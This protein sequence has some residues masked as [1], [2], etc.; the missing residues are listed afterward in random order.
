MST[1]LPTPPNASPDIRCG[2][3]GHPLNGARA[4]N[5]R[6]CPG[7]GGDLAD[8]AAP[9]TPETPPA[10]RTPWAIALLLLTGIAIGLGITALPRALAGLFLGDAPVGMI[11]ALTIGGCWWVVVAPL[12]AMAWADNL[13]RV[14]RRRD[15]LPLGGFAP[16]YLGLP[17]YIMMLAIAWPIGWPM[18]RPWVSAATGSGVG[19][20]AAPSAHQLGIP[21]QGSLPTGPQQP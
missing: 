17:V 1:P 10:A 6:A 16:V 8:F 4:N 21:P 18:I 5:D 14:L 11:L 20:A 2:F 19:P 3:C 12:F 9:A 13:I 7:C 15:R